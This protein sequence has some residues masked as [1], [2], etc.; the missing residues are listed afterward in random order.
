[1]E[2]WNGQKVRK[3]ESQKVRMVGKSEWVESRNGLTFGKV[4]WLESRNGGMGGKSVGM[5]G[6]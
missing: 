6:Q 3:S 2:G 1:M 5:V 4:G